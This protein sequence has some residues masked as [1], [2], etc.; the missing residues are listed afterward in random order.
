M[1][2]HKA[3]NGQRAEGKT[4]IQR[5]WDRALDNAGSSTTGATGAA[6]PGD[7]KRNAIQR[8][9]DYASRAISAAAQHRKDRP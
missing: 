7:G 9:W 5:S 8:G 2:S 3:D 4:V 6:A 1:S